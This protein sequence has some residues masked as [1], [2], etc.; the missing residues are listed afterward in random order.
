[1]DQ[2]LIDQIKKSSKALV[3]TYSTRDKMLK[4][5]REIYFMDN[6]E[7]QRDSETDPSD[8]KVTASPSGRNSVVGIHR[9]LKT[10]ELQIDIRQGQAARPEHHRS[11]LQEDHSG[12]Q[13]R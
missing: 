11:R 8:I 2:K 6:I 1:M 10:S 3:A 7:K 4:R 13:R 9:L 5:Y 12:E